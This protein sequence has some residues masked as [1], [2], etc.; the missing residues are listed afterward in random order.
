M[1]QK[2]NTRNLSLDLLKALAIYLVVFFHNAQL[3]PDSFI[4]N[5]C[6]LI[7]YAAVP[8]FFMASGAVFFHRPFQMKK[9]MLRTIR[10]YL[11]V[12]AWKAIYL[13]LYLHWGV[14]FDGSIRKIFSYL[15]LFQTWHGIQ[16][17]HFWFMDAMLTVMLAAPLLYL[18][19]H[20]KDDN[21]GLMSRFFPGH[22][23]LLWYLLAVLIIF[24]QLTADGSL[25]MN[26]LAMLLKKPVLDVTPLGEI[27]PFSFRYSDYFTYYLLGGLLIEQKERI[28]KKAAITM[29]ALGMIGLLII[30][31]IQTGSW[32]WSGILLQSGYYWI[33]TMALSVSL[34]VLALYLDV[35]AQTIA[36]RVA[37]IAGGSTMGIFYLHIPLIYLLTPQLFDSFRHWNSWLLNTAESLLICLI[38]LI[39]TQAGKRI[40]V[41]RGLFGS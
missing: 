17:D 2:T 24:N 16:T 8:C 9:H 28:T 41:L 36:G 12:A 33:S 7:P 37:G 35:Q 40:P 34:F 10:L 32:L 30:K 38:A 18:Y 5:L 26:L 27:N 20:T 3:N 21:S 11:V 6:M 31:Y 1:P 39:I 13:A 22:S 15:F 19:F 23:Q 14:A 4:D 29:A 25:L